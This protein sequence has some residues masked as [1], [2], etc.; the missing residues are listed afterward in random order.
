MGFSERFKEMIDFQH[1]E[2]RG[3]LGLYIGERMVRQH[4]PETAWTLSLLNLELSDDVLELGCGAGYAMK[5]LLKESQVNQAVGLD[6]SHSILRSA[7]IRNRKEIKMG[8]ARFLHGN[9]NQLPFKNS[10]FSK[11]FS[12]HS[13]YFWEDLPSSLSEIYRVL[14]PGGCAIITYCNGKN[15]ETWNDIEQEI[16][17]IMKQKGFKKVELLKGPHSREFHTAAVVGEKQAKVSILP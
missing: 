3:L 2:P 17:P 14:K 1:K 5:L 12:I 6:L 13:V 16:I 4:R 15:E 8:K 10:S 9:V 11:I 7:A